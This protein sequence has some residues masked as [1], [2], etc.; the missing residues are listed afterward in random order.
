MS[1]SF[2]SLKKGNAEIHTVEHILA[3]I[4]GSGID[5]IIIEVDN[6][7]IPILDGSAQKFSDTI[8]KI[9]VISQKSKR[10]YFEITKT[11]TFTDEKTGAKLVVIPMNDEGELIISEFDKL[12]CV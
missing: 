3:A 7:E 2:F 8:E 1:V 11:F 10:K 6:I 5:N 9:G 12:K 4:T